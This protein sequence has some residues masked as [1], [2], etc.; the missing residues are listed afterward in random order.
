M[1]TNRVLFA[2][3]LLVSLF[4]AA[5]CGAQLQ[6]QPTPSQAPP[7]SEA[8]LTATASASILQTTGAPPTTSAPDATAGVAG[9]EISGEGEVTLGPGE[10]DFPDTTAGLATLSSYKATLTLSFAGTQ[11]GQA[12]Q[13]L[14]TYVML[15]TQQPSARQVTIESTGDSVNGEPALL[16]EMAGAAYEQR[17]DG[18]CSASATDPDQS[19]ADRM[20]PAGFLTGVFGAEQAGSETVN[21]VAADRYTFDERAL[22]ETGLA[23][24]E[25]Q[26]WV[27]TDGGHLVRYALTTT[28]GEAYFGPGIEGTAT[29][30]Y[31]LTDVNQ[32]FPITL[33]ADCPAGLIDAP[34]LPDAAEVLDEPGVLSYVTARAPAEALLFYQGELSALGWQA[35]AEPIVEQAMAL[36][37]FTRD[38]QQLSL[39]ITATDGV[40]TVLAVSGPIAP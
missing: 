17:G 4:F 40:T 10:F 32:S 16:A 29:W 2:V 1:S 26:L 39:V 38:G 27:A 19:L 11:A 13:W 8:G 22:G 5:A 21:L 14:K 28:G 3:A 9:E 7:A 31:E 6:S 18:R 37:D 33:P 12:S 25:G 20:E 34:M 23:Q 15:S 36:V 24:S 35:K 30:A